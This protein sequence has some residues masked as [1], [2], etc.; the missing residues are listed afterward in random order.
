MLLYHKLFL[1]KTSREVGSPWPLGA[2]KVRSAPTHPPHNPSRSTDQTKRNTRRSHFTQAPSAHTMPQDA[3]P[4]RRDGTQ[5]TL[6]SGFGSTSSSISRLRSWTRTTS[7]QRPLTLKGPLLRLATS[8]AT[9]GPINLAE[10]RP[11]SRWM[12][13]ANTSTSPPT[14]PAVL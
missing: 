10:H 14:P 9:R 12:A 5:D 6:T 4:Q 2:E 3:G 1:P 7:P 11:R 8:P 13:A